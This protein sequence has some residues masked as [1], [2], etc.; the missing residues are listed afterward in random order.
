M[1]VILLKRQTDT[2]TILLL[3]HID[4]KIYFS[5]LESNLLIHLGGLWVFDLIPLVKIKTLADDTGPEFGCHMTIFVS[6]V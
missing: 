2:Q 6:H 5:A 4:Q 1:N 3:L